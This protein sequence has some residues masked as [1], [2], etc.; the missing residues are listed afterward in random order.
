DEVRTTA[1]F[2]QTGIGR[3][4][5]GGGHDACILGGH[6]GL[7]EAGRRHYDLELPEIVVRHPLRIWPPWQCR[8]LTLHVPGE[9][10]ADDLH[11]AL[12]AVKGCAATPHR[13]IA[14]APR[15]ILDPN[16]GVVVDRA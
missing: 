3:A 8:L 13:V 14:A 6:G 5:D 16:V 12:V 11:D 4:D 10:A 1:I 15:E 2:G 9:A 7:Q